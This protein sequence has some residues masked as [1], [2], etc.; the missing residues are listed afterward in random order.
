M[1][2]IFIHTKIFV[3]FYA[4]CHTSDFL[5]MYH[6]WTYN[7][8]TGSVEAIPLFVNIGIISQVKEFNSIIRLDYVTY[9]YFSQALQSGQVSACLLQSF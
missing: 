8:L 9:N 1:L 3:H 5:S 2:D 6:I 4:C 7:I